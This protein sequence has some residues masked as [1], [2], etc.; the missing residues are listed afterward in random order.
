MLLDVPQIR[1]DPSVAQIKL[2]QCLLIS[3]QNWRVVKPFVN[4]VPVLI[5][6]FVAHLT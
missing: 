5:I 6:V 2:L 3:R 4:L 1:E